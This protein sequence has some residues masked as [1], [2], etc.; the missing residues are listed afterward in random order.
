MNLN[1]KHCY[2][3]IS[4]RFDEHM[5][6]NGSVRTH[7]K[8]KFETKNDGYGPCHK[9]IYWRIKT[10]A[11]MREHLIILLNLFF[12]G[13]F[14]FSWRIFS[15]SIWLASL[16]NCIRKVEFNGLVFDIESCSFEISSILSY[17]MSTVLS[18]STNLSEFH[19]N[20]FF[21]VQNC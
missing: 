14:F 6:V 17:G 10:I 13:N 7:W 11:L 18:M 15:E 4:V 19:V 16:M 9:Y 3:T 1:W 5:C 21:G 12:S 8:K 20:S 2:V